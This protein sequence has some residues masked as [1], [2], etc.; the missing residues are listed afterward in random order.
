MDNIEFRVSIKHCFFFPWQK[1]FWLCTWKSIVEKQFSKFKRGEKSTEDD[2][3]SWRPKKVNT[4]IYDDRIMM[5]IQK[6]ESLNISSWICKSCVQNF[7]RSKSIWITFKNYMHVFI[8]LIYIHYKTSMKIAIFVVSP[9]MALIF[10]KYYFLFRQRTFS[11]F[12]C[13]YCLF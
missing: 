12:Y 7:E 4:I 6:A 3:R 2:V 10:N 5:L 13:S 1:L 9:S 11:R 8:V